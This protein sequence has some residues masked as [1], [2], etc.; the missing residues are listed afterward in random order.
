MIWIPGLED[1]EVE[2]GGRD[3]ELALD[4]VAENGAEDA[5]VEDDAGATGIAILLLET[6][7]ILVVAL[8]ELVV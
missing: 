1:A 7:L 4:G 6:L 5:L 2:G 3:A 8:V